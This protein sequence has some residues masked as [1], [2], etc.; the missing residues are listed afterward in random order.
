[1]NS[2]IIKYFTFSSVFFFFL[3]PKTLGSCVLHD[4]VHV[5]SPIGEIPFGL[6]LNY[7]LS[8]FSGRVSFAEP[9]IQNV[10]RDFEIEMPI[11]V[12]ESPPFR[13]HVYSRAASRVR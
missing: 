13:T 1:M 11:V 12:E 7:T 8:S 3:F 9:N 10:P 5:C 2:L 4:S 6:L